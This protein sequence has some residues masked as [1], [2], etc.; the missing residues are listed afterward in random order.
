MSDLVREMP[1][2]ERLGVGVESAIIRSTASF[3]STV[4]PLPML[5]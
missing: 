1:F 5:A 2:A 3:A 4:T